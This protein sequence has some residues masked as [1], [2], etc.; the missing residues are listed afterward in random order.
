[1]KRLLIFL[2]I[3]F[4]FCSKGQS[5]ELG[6]S[7]QIYSLRGLDGMIPGIPIVE[8]KYVIS[9]IFSGSIPFMIKEDK[10]RALVLNPNLSLG[11]SSQAFSAEIPLYL[12]ARYGAGAYKGYTKNWGLGVGIGPQFC[13]LSTII[14]PWAPRILR[15]TYVAPSIAGEFSFYSARY[16]IMRLRIDFTP[17]PAHYRSMVFKGDISQ[18]NFRL[19]RSL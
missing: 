8:N 13:Y 18:L 3:I 7:F 12:M 17:L 4:P 1:M 11:S 6:S 19:I 10:E 2:I 15:A 5:I 9:A 14:N 16:N